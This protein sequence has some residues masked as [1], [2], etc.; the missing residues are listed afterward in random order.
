MKYADL[1]E[2]AISRNA[3]DI[4]VSPGIT[5]VLRV[6]GKMEPVDFPESTEE[7]MLEWLLS[8]M[9]EE[10]RSTFLSERDVDFAYNFMGVRFRV[11]A[12]FQI[13]GPS[14]VFRS[15]PGTVPSLEDVMAPEIVHKLL[16]L[17]NGLIL[18]TGTTGSGKSTT[19]A[20]MVR[21]VNET[22]RKHI[23]TLEDPIEFVHPEGFSLITQREVHSH[24]Q[25]FS[26]ALRAALREDPDIIMVGEMRD[27]ETVRL[28]LTAAETGHL[29]IGTLHTGSAAKAVTRIV[30][31]FPAEEKEL[32]RSMLAESLQGVILQTLV[33]RKGGGRVAA[34]EVML[35]TPAV[36]NFIRNDK[37]AMV[38]SA[39]Q[40]GKAQGM[41]SLAQSLADLAENGHVEEEVARRL[42]AS[43]GGF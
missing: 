9:G 7:Q 27:L 35:G 1:L 31:V 20:A 19:Q 5:P 38:G 10:Q 22:A 21:Y 6:N 33:E 11:N 43:F 41:I 39:I 4:H 15:I 18:L 37:I 12:F 30:D 8:M 32:V 42:T 17:Q 40:T 13:R 2:F 23:I 36:R 29:V 24:T 14:A 3:S 25:S 28:A 16:S 34:F 26:A